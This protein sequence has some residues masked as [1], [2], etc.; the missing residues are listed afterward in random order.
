MLTFD[1]L[2]EREG[3][4]NV[5]VS[6]LPEQIRDDDALSDCL[7]VLGSITCSAKIHTNPYGDFHT[8]NFRGVVLS[9]VFGFDGLKI[10]YTSTT[11]AFFMLSMI[12]HL[13]YIEDCLQ[14]NIVYA[15]VAAV[16]AV[17]VSICIIFGKEFMNGRGEGLSGNFEITIVDLNYRHEEE[18]S[19][20]DDWESD[21]ETATTM[22][23]GEEDDDIDEGLSSEQKRT[24]RGDISRIPRRF[25]T[26]TAKDGGLPE[27][28]RR[29]KSTADWRLRE[30]IDS[31]LFKPFPEFMAIKKAYPQSHF[32]KTRPVFKDPDS[33]EKYSHLVYYEKPGKVE[34][35]VL[36]KIGMK[37]VQHFVMFTCEWNYTYMSPHERDKVVNVID[38]SEVRLTNIRGNTLEFFKFIASLSQDHYPERAAVIIVINAPTWFAMIWRVVKPLINEATQQKIRI[39]NSKETLKGLTEFVPL[40]EIPDCYGGA[41]KG[42]FDQPNTTS[43]FEQGFIEYVE[44]LNSGKPLPRPPHFYRQDVLS[45]FRDME[46]VP[47]FWEGGDDKSAEFL[48]DLHLPLAEQKS[49]FALLCQQ[50]AANSTKQANV[51]SV[52]RKSSELPEYELQE[53]KIMEQNEKITE[54][55]TSRDREGEAWEFSANGSDSPF[56]TVNQQTPLQNFMGGGGTPPV[57]NPTKLLHE[58]WVYKKASGEGYHNVF[59]RRNWAPRWAKLVETNMPGSKVDVPAIYFFWFEFSTVPSS[60]FILDGCVC[61]P[62]DRRE[63]EFNSFCFDIVHLP[64]TRMGRSLSTMN[65]HD[66]DIWVVNVNEAIDSFEMRAERIKGSSSEVNTPPT[67]RQHTA[68]DGE[69]GGGMSSRG[70]HS[71]EN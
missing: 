13:R 11:I 21:N 10:A 59:G 53:K 68:I 45:S 5:A 8:E 28:K 20:S 14:S 46:N 51:Y 70:Y 9:S 55:I 3:E 16:L 49:K 7:S 48:S 23:I 2:R 41:C 44:R 6:D 71:D 32:R 66:R 24:H 43:E 35:D 34:M 12:W 15:K 67:E 33:D 57:F 61:V 39:L 29:W 4:F 17:I 40:E 37:V 42:I 54:S 22:D 58:G 1:E 52:G 69:E 26:G 63:K 64:A 56:M 60:V 30:N 31:I 50:R 47:N 65:V 27:A 18:C 62:V 19:V 36:T 38:V 25:I